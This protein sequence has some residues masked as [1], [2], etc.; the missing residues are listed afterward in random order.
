MRQEGEDGQLVHD[1][2]TEQQLLMLAEIEAEEEEK[3]AVAEFKRRLDFNMG[4]VRI[5]GR[6]WSFSVHAAN[7]R[8]AT[9]VLPAATA[10]L[11]FATA[12]QCGCP[13]TDHSGNQWAPEQ[14]AASNLF[15]Q[16]CA[17]QLAPGVRRESRITRPPRRPKDG[18]TLVV[19]PLSR[20][21]NKVGSSA[22]LCS[23]PSTDECSC[24]ACAQSM[25][26]HAAG[27]WA[28]MCIPLHDDTLRHES[29]PSRKCQQAWG[30]M[31][32]QE[33]APAYAA[34]P[35][36]RARRLTESEAVTLQRGKPLRRRRQA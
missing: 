19:Q 24:Y 35:S 21:R 31:T 9:A 3:H 36:G 27:L 32:S 15:P 17:A 30:R 34:E 14:P 18:W 1:G 26:W 10:L 29:L 5:C 25:L 12:C 11:L 33:A 8:H 23:V 7:P 28:S 16:T 4:R 6:F 20:R 22:C 2:L 13:S